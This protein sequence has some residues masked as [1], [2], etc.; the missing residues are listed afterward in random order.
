MLGRADDAHERLAHD[1]P[2]DDGH[3]MLAYD[4]CI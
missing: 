4:A 1:E 3:M 2:A